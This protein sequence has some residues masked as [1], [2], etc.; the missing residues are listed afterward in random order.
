MG[1]DPTRW[2]RREDVEETVEET[3]STIARLPLTTILHVKAGVEKGMG[4]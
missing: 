4:R 2:C 3:A 1:T